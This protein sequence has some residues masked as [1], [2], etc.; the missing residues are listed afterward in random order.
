MAVKAFVMQSRAWPWMSA[1]TTRVPRVA[2]PRP[3]AEI[4]EALS[5]GWGSSIAA[6]ASSAA[7]APFTY[8][9]TSAATDRGSEPPCQCQEFVTTLTAVITRAEAAHGE[10]EKRTR[11][12]DAD[13]PTWYA[14][15]IVAEQAGTEPPT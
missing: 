13:W 5:G 11:Q 10:H 3:R 15:Y 6:D 9:S 8:A 1:S 14:E 7:T 12:R 2:V 4:G